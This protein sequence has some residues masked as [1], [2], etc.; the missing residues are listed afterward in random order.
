MDINDYKY[1]G[2]IG[3]DQKSPNDIDW[4]DAYTTFKETRDAHFKGLNEYFLTS[5][6]MINLEDR[7]ALLS[8]YDIFFEKGRVFRPIAEE[9]WNSLVSLP[10][11]FEVG[12]KFTVSGAVPAEVVTQ[13]YP[14]NDGKKSLEVAQVAGE[15]K[16]LKAEEK[17]TQWAYLSEE[18]EYTYTIFTEELYNQ[19]TEALSELM[20][21]EKELFI[22]ID[23][24]TFEDYGTTTTTS[25]TTLA[26]FVITLQMQLYLS[27][28]ARSMDDMYTVLDRITNDYTKGNY[29]SF[30]TLRNDHLA[31]PSD[32][33]LKKD[34]NVISSQFFSKYDTYNTLNGIE[35]SIE[36]LL[37]NSINLPISI[38]T[39]LSD[40]VSY[41]V[42]YDA[43]LQVIMDNDILNQK[44]KILDTYTTVKQVRDSAELYIMEND[45]LEVIQKRSLSQNDADLLAQGHGY[46]D[47]KNMVDMVDLYKQAYDYYYYSLTDSNESP[48]YIFKIESFYKY[49]DLYNGLNLLD[50]P[51]EVNSLMLS[52]ISS[53]GGIVSSIHTKFDGY[54]NEIDSNYTSY[55]TFMTDYNHLLELKDDKTLTPQQAKDL[56]KELAKMSQVFKVFK[57]YLINNNWYTSYPSLE[58][59]ELEI[60]TLLSNH[61]N[62]V[63]VEIKPLLSDISLGRSDYHDSIVVL[64]KVLDK[65]NGG[66]NTTYSTVAEL[67]SAYGQ[68]IS[69]D[70]KLRLIE[71]SIKSDPDA[72]RDLLAQGY[73]Y[74]NFLKMR[75]DVDTLSIGYQ[76][77]LDIVDKGDLFPVYYHDS[78]IRY[79]KLINELILF[80]PTTTTTSTTTTTTIP[81][82]TISG[83]MSVLLGE[84]LINKDDLYV[85]LD[86]LTNDVSGGE[87]T[88]FNDLRT[89]YLIDY[90]PVVNGDTSGSE[91]LNTMVI[92][93]YDQ[94]IRLAAVDPKLSQLVSFNGNAAVSAT[95]LYW[96]GAFNTLQTTELSIENLLDSSYNV[97][98]NITTYLSSATSSRGLYD[99]HLTGILETDKLNSYSI[100]NDYATIADLRVAYNSYTTEDDK[101][102]SIYDDLTYHD[103]QQDQSEEGLR[104]LTAYA[105]SLAQGFGYV[106]LL[107]MGNIVNNTLLDA[108]DYYIEI[109]HIF[110]DLKAKD[111]FIKKTKADAVE[112]TF[113]TRRN[114]VVDI[115]A[116]E[117]FYIDSMYKYIDLYNGLNSLI[118][119]TPSAAI[120]Y[121]DKDFN[122][123]TSLRRKALGKKESLYLKLIY[124]DNTSEILTFGE[125][126]SGK[127]QKTIP[128]GRRIEII[129]CDVNGDP[130]GYID[131]IR[132]NGTTSIDVTDLTHLTSLNVTHTSSLDVTG[133]TNLTELVVYNSPL[134]SLD[135][136]SL[137]NLTSLNVVN[138][139]L[140]SLD[141]T[142]LNNLTYLD[143]NSNSLTSLDVTGLTNLTYL[144]ANS[145]SLT[146]LDVNSLT[147]LQSL[148]VNNNSLTSLDVTGLTNLTYLYVNGNS[149]NSSDVDGLLIELDTNGLF[150]GNFQVDFF[151]TSASDSAYSDLKAKGWNL[152]IP[153]PPGPSLTIPINVN[154][155]GNT[156]GNIG[157][158]T[159]HIKVTY[160]DNTSEV[161]SGGIWTN[162]NQNTV[163]FARY[164]SSPIDSMIITSCLS[165]GTPSG[166]ILAAYLNRAEYGNY[167]VSSLTTL[168][169]LYIGSNQNITSI[170]TT[171]NKGLGKLNLSRLTNLNYLYIISNSSLTSIDVTSLTNLSQLQIQEN[172]S[173]TSIDVTGLTNLSYLSVY[174]NT[175]ITSIDLT[176][177]TNLTN[178]TLRYNSSLTSIDVTGL[179]NLRYLYTSILIEYITG[180]VLSNLYNLGVFDTSLTSLDLTGLTGLTNLQYLSV[181]NNQLLTSLDVTSLTNLN[182]LVIYQNNSLTSLDVTGLTNLRYLSHYDNQSLTSIDITSLT[183]LYQ[184][185]VSFSKLTS[186]DLTGST[187]LYSLYVQNNQLITSLDVTSLT[188]LYLLQVYNNPLIT[189]LDVTGLTNLSYLNTQNSSLNSSDVDGLLIELSNN[190]HTN[191]YFNDG[192]IARTSASDSAYT[193]LISKGWTLQLG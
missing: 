125:K 175:S 134:T 79:V 72:D 24:D 142:G 149:F 69:E 92:E 58:T 123:S 86:S 88:S 118:P 120:I 146:S 112:K 100:S 164:V 50:L 49:I 21:S 163:Y 28:F 25:T 26:P 115:K 91:P 85:D 177:L 66:L 143:A 5:M 191:G 180:L 51:F 140:T 122:V 63:P 99:I 186:L 70:E 6:T 33:Q 161:Y 84:F 34:Y 95:P 141:V 2:I 94:V 121:S 96:L 41:R 179:T 61:Y 136:T 19:Y 109:A 7:P 130:F 45:K 97:P 15:N 20:L 132:I 108:H 75:E 47:L 101:L 12:N 102:Q 93:Y 170:D 37:N 83:S 46:T 137:T 73:G 40:I 3:T 174:N 87:Y 107:D 116:I 38:S 65:V 160:S 192:N 173:L 74:T 4:R 1:W 32:K 98:S 166:N 76:L 57:V 117:Y 67:I 190:G 150:N 131:N 151:K 138:T 124:W 188:N 71:I 155:G 181:Q 23:G 29:T 172:S 39:Y 77:Y 139:S 171:G 55:E 185:E 52:D 133:L 27:S 90:V 16:K 31:S 48:L 145:N 189:S 126:I 8:K 78:L 82:F 144:D 10:V 54:I 89:Q 169:S 81:Q 153:E 62:K 113:F 60:E 30:L 35:L 80:A 129:S 119:V 162:N 178:L 103:L 104:T 157:T 44:Y 59:S 159:G 68:F 148:N 106:D 11:S 110:N 193:D 176:S 128:S 9:F 14:S 158:S 43:T 147:N 56:E 36:Q 114:Y 184:L 18:G 187:N 127:I 154:V 183:N 13:D 53:I 111:D 105:D 156:Y 17:T 22:L 135:V 152:T 64:Q 182:Q 165:D 168:K 167:D 42:A